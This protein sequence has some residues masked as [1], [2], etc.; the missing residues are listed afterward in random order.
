[1]DQ[2]IFDY[3]SQEELNTWI[4]ERTKVKYQYSRCIGLAR[5][6]ELIACVAYQQ[7]DNLMCAHIALDKPLTK[8]FLRI[9]FDYPFNQIKTERLIGLVPE[10]NKKAIKLNEKLGFRLMQHDKTMV[11]QM[12]KNECKWLKE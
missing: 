3:E 4:S 9:I 12:V 10:E 5:D 11:F 6:G 8:S 7:F 2:I 1:V